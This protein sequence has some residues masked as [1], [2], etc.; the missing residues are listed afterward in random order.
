MI[1]K[2]PE[3]IRYVDMAIWVDGCDLNP[4]SSDA[5]KEKAFEY[6]YHL[7]VM[8]AVKQCYFKTG[9]DYDN[10]GVYAAT[11]IYL[12]YM[13]G[14]KIKSC[15]NYLKNVVYFIK[16]DYSKEEFAQ[17]IT[18]DDTENPTNTFD[19]YNMLDEPSR[20]LERV[21]FTCCLRDI[22]DSVKHFLQIIPYKKDSVTW[23]NI[24]LSCLLTL[25]DSI[26]L[27]NANIKDMN[28][29]PWKPESIDYLIN[30]WFHEESKITKARLYHLDDS[31]NDYIILLCREIK[32]FICQD[33]SWSIKC[34]ESFYQE[35]HRIAYEGAL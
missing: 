9:R 3:D 17:V 32:D 25:L 4:N 34:N 23:N 8:L 24:Y 26:T 30:R 20:Q 12:I 5:I 6:L 22:C 1:F 15:L 29:S 27:K 13:K 28:E 16:V 14:K 33:L 2:K 21:E 19:L 11:R 7:S 10:F 31:F 35:N 18:Y